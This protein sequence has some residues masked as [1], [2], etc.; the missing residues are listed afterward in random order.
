MTRYARAGKGTHQRVAKDPTNWDEL[1]PP[2]PQRLRGSEEPEKSSRPARKERFNKGNGKNKFTK[3]PKPFS[4][5]SEGLSKGDDASAE[6]VKTFNR[7]AKARNPN[8]RGFGE[9]KSVKILGQFWVP[10][11]DA[12][13]LKGLLHKLKEQGL[14]RKEILEILKNDRRKAEKASKRQRDKT[15]FQCR[16]FGHV[17][18]DCPNLKQ[19][20]AMPGSDGI[21]E[22]AMIADQGLLCFKCGSME[23]TSR[24]CRRQG[25]NFE[26]AKCFIC[27]G[28]GHI[29]R[30]CPQNSNGIYPSGGSCGECGS[31]THLKKDCPDIVGLEGAPAKEDDSD[32]VTLRMSDPFSSTEYEPI[33]DDKVDDES[34]IPQSNTPIMDSQTTFQR[35]PQPNRPNKKGKRKAGDDNAVTDFGFGNNFEPTSA[36]P[37]APK[38]KKVVKF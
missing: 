7:N 24:K 33:M 18:S 37:V 13:R 20:I 31:S 34:V 38:K 32:A 3:H 17:L 4:N 21:E 12:K 11:D 25:E 19:A 15:C 29:A 35:K 22:A 30:Q 14:P 8:M 5:S 2:P 27:S 26:F 16:Q 36:K 23:H 6:P 10:L 28:S 9:G 1:K